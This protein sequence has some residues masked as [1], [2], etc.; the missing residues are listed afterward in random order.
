MEETETNAGT[1][2]TERVVPYLQLVGVAQHGLPVI[3][4]IGICR[5]L[6]RSL[7]RLLRQSSISRLQGYV[8]KL[9]N[10]AKVHK[11]KA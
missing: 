5:L 7:L 9:E 3:S 11:W 6:L 4:W 2:F 10:V 1:G 8:S